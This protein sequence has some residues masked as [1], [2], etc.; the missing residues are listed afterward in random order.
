MIVYQGPSN[1]DGK[2][3]VA[4]ATGLKSGSSNRKTGDLVQV[5]ILPAGTAP[6]DAAKS[7]ADRSVCGSCIHRPRDG[8]L[9]S[10]YVDLG[11]GPTQVYKSYQLGSYRTYDR[12]D[13]LELFAGRKIRLG[14]YGDPAAVPVRIWREILSV[15][16]GWTGYTH[17][18]RR[19]SAQ[20]LKVW[21]LA[22]CD[23]EADRIEAQ[24]KG[25]R[26]FRVMRSDE[27]LGKGEFACPAS[28]EAGKR[29]TCAECM[30]CSG[31]DSRK[32][33]PAIYVHGLDWKKTKYNQTA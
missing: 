27:S 1:L 32:A 23:S 18:W 8:K 4:I 6:I 25:W 10:C 26:T 15:A 24:A 21:C 28:E 12:A 3:I 13:H 30:A 31:G 2:P 14:A 22:S 7:G 11:K 5:Y 16:D 20:P 33:S 9:G 17:Q 29:L 19:Q